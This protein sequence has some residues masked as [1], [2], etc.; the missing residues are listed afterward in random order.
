MHVV[1][2]YFILKEPSL[3]FKVKGLLLLLPETQKNVM[4]SECEYIQFEK[5]GGYCGVGE[6][7]LAQLL[8]ASA[9]YT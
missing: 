1:A 6:G 3:Q 7:I 5:G 4:K 9:K 8:R 2:A